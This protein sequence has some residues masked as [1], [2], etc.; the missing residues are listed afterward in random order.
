MDQQVKDRVEE[1]RRG[2]EESLPPEAR[3]A[4]QMSQ[5]IQSLVPTDGIERYKTVE[6][7]PSFDDQDNMAAIYEYPGLDIDD[8]DARRLWID[9]LALSRY[10]LV[11][12]NVTGPALLPVADDDMLPTMSKG[13][14]VIFDTTDT[15]LGN[16]SKPRVVRFG[17]RVLIRRLKLTSGWVIMRGDNPN[18]MTNEIAM[19]DGAGVGLEI[20]GRV[21]AVIKG[22]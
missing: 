21:A 12:F 11:K 1:A 5:A 17:G 20:L 15:G 13:D 2:F 9:Q 18:T 19:S 10:W 8:P 7:V 4:M 16:D 3:F 14:V 6:K 22:V